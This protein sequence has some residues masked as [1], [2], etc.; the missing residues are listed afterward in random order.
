MK[1]ILINHDYIILPTLAEAWVSGSL[2]RV[3]GTECGSACT[4][5]YEGDHH[6]LH[7]NRE[8]AQPCPLTENWIKDSLS[9][10]L[11]IKARPSFPSVSLSHQEV[12]ISLLSLSIKGQTK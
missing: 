4:G 12:S 9:M 11:H 1:L 5:P 7:Y 10:A 8:G 2:L 6:Y 3:G